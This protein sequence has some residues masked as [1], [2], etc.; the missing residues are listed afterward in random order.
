MTADR[1]N[2]IWRFVVAPV[3]ALGAIGI[4]SAIAKPLAIV[5]ETPSLPR[6]LYVRTAEPITHGAIVAFPQPAKARAY[7]AALDYP[8]S[9]YLLKRVT[10]LAGE[11]APTTL[12][13][14]TADRAGRP[15][16]HTE[17]AAQLNE[18]EVFVLGDT[19]AR[20][21]DSRYFGPIAASDIVGT[22]RLVWSW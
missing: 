8:A 20:S 13:R 7:L 22:Y 2:R 4:V 18:G 1:T 21:F 14:L 9:A 19:G 11:A 5:N 6:G 12:P 17:T 3:L 10:T 16:P 15:L